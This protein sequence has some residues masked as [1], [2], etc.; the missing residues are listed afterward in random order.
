[1]AFVDGDNS[2]AIH[3]GAARARSG[4]ASP[5]WSPVD[6]QEIHCMIFAARLEKPINRLG[7]PSRVWITT[8]IDQ[9]GATKAAFVVTELATETAF[10]IEHPDVVFRYSPLPTAAT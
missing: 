6:I 3:N 4:V 8:F 5:R 10:G 2:K 7:N 1:M 9:R